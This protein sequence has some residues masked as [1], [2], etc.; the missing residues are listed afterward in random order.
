MSEAAAERLGA[1]CVT[2]PGGHTAPLDMPVAFA[3]T[4]RDLLHRI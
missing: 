3:A 2:F 4:L 1:A